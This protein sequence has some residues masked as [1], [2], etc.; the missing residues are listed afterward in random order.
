MYMFNL[1]KKPHLIITESELLFRNDPSDVDM[2]RHGFSSI[3]H[4][5][6]IHKDDRRKE[7]STWLEIN[8]EDAPAPLLLQVSSL[9]EPLEEVLTHLQDSV[10]DK[11]TF[12]SSKNTKT[13]AKPLSPQRHLLVLFGFLSLLGIAVL[14]HTF[15]PPNLEHLE[16]EYLK[17]DYERKDLLCSARA[18]AAYADEQ[19]GFV[20]IKHFC[21]LM[22]LWYEESQTS[23]EQR[24]LET[25]FSP[26][27][28][29]DYIKAARQQIENKEYHASLVSLEKAIY[30]NDTDPEAYLLLAYNYKQ[31]A[32]SALALQNY[33][34]ALALNPKSYEAC[35]AI[36][37]LYL[38][39]Q[40]YEKAYAYLE[41]SVW[42]KP[43]PETY[44]SLAQ[45][46]LQMG[47]S[48]K[49]ITHFEHALLKD[50]N[51][52]HVLH[53]LGLL[54]WQD[55]AYE[56]AAKVFE[57]AYSELPKDPKGL[58]NYYEISL[59]TSA[60]L[61]EGDKENF[62]KN[63]SH[64]KSVLMVY[65]MLHIIEKTIKQ[66]DVLDLLK[67]WDRDYAG[68]KLDWSL[69]QIR[70]WLDRSSLNDEAQYKIKKIIGFFIAYQQIYN[71][72]HQKYI[73]G[74]NI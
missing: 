40:E 69:T 42:I 70:S 4:I 44:I 38:E 26:L 1:N 12:F 7:P 13:D 22:G 73:T 25:E 6:V 28:Y 60:S 9:D 27:E 68:L 15:F 24:H 48:Q 54:Y 23:I 51:N 34:K 20:K 30:H 71:L 31:T 52:L 66:E 10:G 45:V 39:A 57:R 67:Q 29:S 36:A 58:L 62:L 41:K 35:H 32:K 61:S 37:L 59:I 5:S 74:E 17:A 18:K 56:K 49:A 53:K 50:A 16:K 46:A 3:H 14:F 64:D 2:Q 21:G 19:K 8:M 72:E 33:L 63:F 47:K 65:D 11:L 55:H 43:E